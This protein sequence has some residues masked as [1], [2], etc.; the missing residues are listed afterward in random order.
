MATNYKDREDIVFTDRAT[1]FWNKG[2]GV[3]SVEVEVEDFS[4]SFDEVQKDLGTLSL[5]VYP[6]ELYIYLG[7]ILQYRALLSLPG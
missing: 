4:R 3:A 6:D 2:D 5:I 1:V 7:D